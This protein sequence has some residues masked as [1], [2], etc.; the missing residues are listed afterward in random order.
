MA[1][2]GVYLETIDFKGKNLTV[3]SIDPDDPAVVAATVINGSNQ[4]SVVTFSG[5]EDASCVLAG[6]TITGGNAKKGGGIYC[7]DD[8]SPTIA[9]CT[10]TNNS[11]TH[12]G[13][14]LYTDNSNPTVLNCTFGGNS[15]SLMGGGMYNA[16]SSTPAVVN[17]TFSGNSAGFF[18]GGISCAGGSV[19][20]T[21]CIL[22]GDT[23]EEVSVLGGTLMITYSD[24]QGGFEGEGNIDA[25]PLFAD[26]ENADYHL[27]SQAGRWDPISQDWVID[28][29][30]SPC[31]DAG[32]PSTPTDLEPSPNGGIINMGAYGG[33]AEA[34]KSPAN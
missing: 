22:W 24:V 15:A 9:N 13:G 1:K 32:D 28:H 14:G 11:A 25:D 12:S 21:N 6:F 10:I 23:P 19:T 2:E 5:G 33:T 16:G 8:S 3:R 17:C 7:G 18:G 27:K 20:L 26:P 30:T 4:D 29:V 31:I 34:S